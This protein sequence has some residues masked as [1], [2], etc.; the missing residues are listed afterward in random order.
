M[1]ALSCVKF[2]MCL[3]KL[4]KCLCTLKKALA[5]MLAFAAFGAAFCC[6]A[7][8]KKNLKKCLSKIKAVM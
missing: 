5:V 3:M 8:N 4:N 7:D 2:F 6:F 1:K